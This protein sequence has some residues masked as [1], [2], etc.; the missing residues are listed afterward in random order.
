MK[1]ESLGKPCQGYLVSI[2]MPVHNGEQYVQ[3]AIKSVLAQTYETFELIVIDDGSTDKSLQI[4]QELKKKDTRIKVLRRTEPSGGPAVPR[5]LGMDIAKGRYLA[6]IDCDDLWYPEKL[7]G[8]VEFMLG[9]EAVISFTAYQRISESGESLRKVRIPNVLSYRDLLQNTAIATSS[10]MVDRSVVGGYRFSNQGHEDYALWLSIVREHGR[11]FGLDKEL[12]EYRVVKGSI[13]SRKLKS[14]AWVWRIYR[15]N[16]GLP[17]LYA[18]WCLLNYG[19]RA[20]A[21][22]FG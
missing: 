17:S 12:I 5:N 2:V 4:I 8:Q 9:N 18:A 21:K 19:F 6:F 15:E 10:V 3:D 11:C 13:S 16:E 1:S 7:Q 20:I 22:R 14:I